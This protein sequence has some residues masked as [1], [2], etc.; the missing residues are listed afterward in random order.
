MRIEPPRVYPPGRL[1][2]MPAAPH[3]LSTL[4]PPSVRGVVTSSDGG[5]RCEWV[6]CTSVSATPSM[7]CV[8]SDSESSNDAQFAPEKFA[9]EKLRHLACTAMTSVSQIRSCQA[10]R[11]G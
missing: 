11:R 6:S 4:R 9:P 8:V 7:S 2:V 5:D 10:W 1:R 3:Y